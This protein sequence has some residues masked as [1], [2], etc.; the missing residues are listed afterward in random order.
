[1]STFE[2]SSIR[3]LLG[4]TWVPAADLTVELPLD[5]LEPPH[6]AS[7]SAAKRA[8]PPAAVRVVSEV[9]V[10]CMPLVLFSLDYWDRLDY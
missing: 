7:A 4:A 2:S 6:A 1:V 10:E 8:R 9:S 3:R 5:P